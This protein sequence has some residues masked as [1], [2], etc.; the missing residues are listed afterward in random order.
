M[1]SGDG[2]PPDTARKFWRILNKS[3][4]SVAAASDQP[5]P[6]SNGKLQT[7]TNEPQLKVTPSNKSLTIKEDTPASAN[8]S[9]LARDTKVTPASTSQSLLDG[10]TKVI[11]ASAST[12]QPLLDR[13]T[14]V[15]AVPASAKQTLLDE[16]Y[17]VTIAP[18]SANQPLLVGDTKVTPAPAPANEPQLVGDNKIPSAP[19]SANQ[20]PLF[21]DTNVTT[22][23]L[24]SSEALPK[25]HSVIESATLAESSQ[26]NLVNSQA[27]GTALKDKNFDELSY[28]ILGLGDTNYTNFCNFGKNLDEKLHKLGA[29]R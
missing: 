17:K 16:D 19:A 6:S 9:L 5:P 26:I 13:D 2:E 25:T 15:T 14:K 3:F 12:N 24:K 20:P 7:Q 21:G 8:Q 29:E 18:A 1:F 28:T 23:A 10:D 27:F 22:V 11:P 4:L